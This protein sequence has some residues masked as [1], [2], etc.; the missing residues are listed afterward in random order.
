MHLYISLP[1]AG[2]DKHHALYPKKGNIISVGKLAGNTC[3]RNGRGIGRKNS[4]LNRVLKQS[5]VVRIQSI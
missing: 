5:R 1:D 2:D 4:S 3:N